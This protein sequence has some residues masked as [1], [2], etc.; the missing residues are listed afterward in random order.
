MV[1]TPLGLD[2]QGICA[3]LQ[4]GILSVCHFSCFQCDSPIS[5]FIPPVPSMPFTSCLSML[6]LPSA[7]EYSA[8]LTCIPLLTTQN[9][10]KLVNCWAWLRVNVAKPGTVHIVSTMWEVGSV[11]SCSHI[12]HISRAGKH[13]PVAYKCSFLQAINAKSLVSFLHTE[14]KICYRLLVASVRT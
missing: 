5:I 4:L 10:I 13:L 9:L 8:S 2:C 14:A 7:Q 12:S 11:I 6:C 1:L 3:F